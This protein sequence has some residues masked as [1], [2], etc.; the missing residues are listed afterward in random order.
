MGGTRL[1]L[2]AW[3]GFGTEEKGLWKVLFRGEG[4]F[5]EDG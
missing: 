1:W 2:L 4:G 3:S 5:W